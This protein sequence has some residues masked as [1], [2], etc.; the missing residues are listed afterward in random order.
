MTGVVTTLVASDDIKS[1]GEQIDDLAL[2]FIAPLGTY[3]CNY[4]GHDFGEFVL[5]TLYFVLSSLFFYVRA[6]IY[7]KSTY[8]RR[9]KY[10]VQSTKHQST[11][12]SQSRWFFYEVVRTRPLYFLD[13]ALL[14]WE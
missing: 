4:S 9:T 2:T 8:N 3:N 10:K 14:D 6:S 11:N 7:L 5:C 13:I 12:L 1:F